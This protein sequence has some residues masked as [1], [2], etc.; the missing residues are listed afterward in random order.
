MVI[1]KLKG[2]LGNQLFQ[3]AA[4]LRL[5]LTKNTKLKVD[6]SAMENSGSC[7]PRSY[8]MNAFQF[9]AEIANPSEVAAHVAPSPGGLKALLSRRRNANPDTPAVERLPCS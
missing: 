4:S 6:L 7:M 5:A 2:G 3:S 8:E 9:S 1:T